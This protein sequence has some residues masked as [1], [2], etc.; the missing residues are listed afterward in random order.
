MRMKI[1]SGSDG[2]V[3]LGIRPIFCVSVA[4]ADIRICRSP[5]RVVLLVRCALFACDIGIDEFFLLLH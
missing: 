5:E 1:G 3:P 4:R 2:R